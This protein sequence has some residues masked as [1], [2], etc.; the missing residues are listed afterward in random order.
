MPCSV[1]LGSRGYREQVVAGDHNRWT[2][3]PEG[4]FICLNVVPH[5]ALPRCSGLTTAPDD[6]TGQRGLSQSA[7]TEPGNFVSTFIDGG[8]GIAAL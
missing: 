8:R 5:E 7:W 2:H 6:S 4:R 1:R 3:L